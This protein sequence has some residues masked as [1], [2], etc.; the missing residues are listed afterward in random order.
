MAQ[1]TNASCNSSGNLEVTQNSD[2]ATEPEL[3]RRVIAFLELNS[4]RILNVAGPRISSAADIERFVYEVLDEAVMVCKNGN[5]TNEL[6]NWT[7]DIR[8]DGTLI[9]ETRSSGRI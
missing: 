6:L 5:R 8:S 2:S 1:I 9:T 3:R 4:I 7:I